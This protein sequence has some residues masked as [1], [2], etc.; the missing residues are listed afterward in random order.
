MRSS[1]S[2][3]VF[4][5]FTP[6]CSPAVPRPAVRDHHI[7]RQFYQLVAENT[8][9]HAVRSAPRRDAPLVRVLRPNGKVRDLIVGSSV[10]RAVGGDDWV[11][12][13]VDADKTVWTMVKDRAGTVFLASP[14]MCVCILG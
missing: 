9:A 12:V 2:P 11:Q 1:P 13:G 6:P 7:A 8:T 3:A 5:V 10:R 4:P 14:G